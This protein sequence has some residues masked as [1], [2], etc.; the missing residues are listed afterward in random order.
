M[1]KYSKHSPVKPADE[2]PLNSALRQVAEQIQRPLPVPIRPSPSMTMKAPLDSDSRRTCPHCGIHLGTTWLAAPQHPKGGMYLWQRCAC[3][4]TQWDAAKQRHA[5]QPP[6]L[7]DWLTGLDRLDLAQF[8]ADDQGR[9][10]HAI[11]TEW[12]SRVVRYESA[13]DHAAR[14]MAALYLVGK[15]SSGKTLLA[16]SLAATAATNGATVGM[17]EER[18]FTERYWSTGHKNIPQLVDAVARDPWLLIVD[19]IGREA[20]PAKSQWRAWASVIEA[21]TL[22]SN[23]TIFTSRV[24]PDELLLRGT[25]DESTERAI[26]RMTTHRTVPVERRTSS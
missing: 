24:T 22:T 6:A 18:S 13:P 19:A 20:A 9:T 7:P 8:Q 16:Q 15:G 26:G 12:L 10:P 2:H 21:R 1:N 11:A 23:W 5:A 4:L 14:P 25:I 3:E 17:I